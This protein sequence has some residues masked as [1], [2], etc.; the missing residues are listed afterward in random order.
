MFRVHSFAFRAEG[1]PVERAVSSDAAAFAN[2]RRCSTW[3]ERSAFS[4]RVQCSGFWVSVLGF[5]VPGFGFMISG[6]GFRIEH[7]GLSVTNKV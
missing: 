4:V 7:L 6:L 5:R 2:V 3:D 1:L